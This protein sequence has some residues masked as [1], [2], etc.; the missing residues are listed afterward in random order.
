MQVAS[1]DGSG[2][3]GLARINNVGNGGEIPKGSVFISSS[4]SSNIKIKEG[5]VELVDNG[6]TSVGATIEKGG[7]QIVTRGGKALNA[8]IEGGQQFVHEEAN[9][10]LK[11]VERRS[12]T[13]DTTVT[14]GRGAIGQQNIYDEAQAWNTKVEND[15]EQNLYAKQRKKGGNAR[16]TEVSG[17]GRQHV[18]A[19]GESYNTTLKDQA[20]QVVYPEGF[21][22]TLTIGGTA[23]SWLHIGAKDVVGEVRVNNGG[24]LYLFAGDVTDHITKKEIPI[25]GR[26]PETIFLV[27]ERHPSERPEI[28]IEDLGGEGG[29]VIFTSIGYDPRHISL[30]VERLS[31]HLHFRFNISPR[32]N[33]SDYLKIEE[34]GT[35][36]HGIS[37]SD[38]GREITAPLSQK[39]SLL[40]GIPLV[41]DRS[42]G[43]GAGFF[44]ESFTGEEIEA[45]DGGAYKYRLCKKGRSADYNGDTITWYL[46][47]E[48]NNSECSNS[49]TRRTGKKPKI[50]TFASSSASETGSPS[51]RRGDSGE[52]RSKPQPKSRPPRHLRGEQQVSVSSPVL[53][54][55]EQL[56]RSD[57]RHPS[58]E[59]YQQPV[60]S[61]GAQSL[62]DK[63]LMRPRNQD[64]L[65]AQSHKEITVS[66]F[67]TT[68]STDAVLSMSVAPGLIFHNELQ[69]VRSGRGVLDKSK[70]NAALWTYGIKS[71]ETIS[72]EHL[73][74]KLEQTGIVLGLSGLSEWEDGEFYIGGFGS[75]DHARLTHARGGVSGLNTYGVGAYATYV[76]Q[77]GWYL[78]GILKY[79]YYQNHL[80]AV[81]TNGSAIAGDYNQWA[82]G[83][84]FEAGY[85]IKTTQSSW[86]QPYGQ[87]TWLQV[88]KKAI[89]LS[90]EMTGDI[91]AF[92][93]LR[94]EVGLS[95]GYEFGSNSSS[96]AY[97]TA[98]W[99]RENKENNQTTI[100]QQHEFSTDISGNAGKLG[101]GLS[102]FVSEKLKLYAQ[103]HYIKG[104]KTKQS[105]QGVLGVRYSF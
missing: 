4:F 53:S 10:D 19:L 18:L 105:F 46:S 71:K 35:G 50:T 79:N 78:D 26:S 54:L 47:M 75:Y 68:P 32:A 44:L 73:D 7:M 62:K 38:S 88:E 42:D 22:D 100:N 48:T 5:G 21:I 99:L 49:S 20:T 24:K 56:S 33:G 17:N 27:G 65:S 80:K 55:Q 60:V 59:E 3:E 94:S 102:S 28:N 43:E 69:A 101:F 6:R 84:S 39:N 63:M 74:F 64:E 92:T 85:R 12:S 58:F 89:E 66:D 13:F 103:A 51:S 34:E 77:S 67:L 72:A 81:S 40:A 11:D 15:G 9:L 16:D 83:T 96:L 36:R 91:N 57:N 98:A 30:A 97:I 82:V 1:A 2:N 61:I 70:K 95:L 45:I 8:K 37:V 31:G 86:L 25:E 87:F 52:Q 76:D 29:T 14:G 23:S 93:S 104:R 41:T 90:N